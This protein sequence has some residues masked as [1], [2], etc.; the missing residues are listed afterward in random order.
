M[1]SVTS[2][3]N[4]S[5][6]TLN[7]P[8]FREIRAATPGDVNLSPDGSGLLTGLV[9]QSGATISAT[10]TAQIRSS[11][12][13]EELVR[14]VSTPPENAKG[15]A[16]Y[17]Y[18]EVEKS[19]G[20][21]PGL[22]I[23]RSVA[24]LLVLAAHGTAFYGSVLARFGNPDTFSWLSGFLGVELFFSLSGFLIGGILIQI[25]AVLPDTRP[26]Q[27]F[28]IRRWMRTYPAYL[29]MFLVLLAV[30]SFDSLPRSDTWKYP[31]LIQNI[32]SHFPK[33]NWF[34][35]SWSLAI[36][37]MSYIFF[38]VTLFL[39]SKISKRT[40]LTLC[41]VI[42]AALGFIM[43][44]AAHLKGSNWDVSVR[45]F[46]LLRLDAIVY[47]VAL[48]LL[49]AKYGSD[50]VTRVCK[51]WFP[52]S[53][54][55]LFCLIA[56]VLKPENLTTGILKTVFLPVLAITICSIFPPFLDIRVPKYL[57][58]VC[59]RISSLS[60]TLYLTH[61]PMISIAGRLPTSLRLLGYLLG[62]F[63]TAWLLSVMVERPL[64]ARRPK[65]FG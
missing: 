12:E 64:M 60:Y 55:T 52:V 1:G 50:A 57:Q 49:V 36:E 2:E 39:C 19:K 7:S 27:R 42:A 30:P 18:A 28:L 15:P 22:D 16:T 40:P 65:Q 5:V 20:H 6:A 25:E 4:N 44:S 11:N 61:W 13:C 58:I 62:S 63:G 47:G 35:P 37:E 24:I 3:R 45:K 14:S 59:H 17:P 46:G 54:A 41:V 56:L 31:L 26:L 53:L 9:A 38:A 29:L 23:V 21:R 51:K 32:F 34:G 33:G 48:S 43:R 8:Q 10:S